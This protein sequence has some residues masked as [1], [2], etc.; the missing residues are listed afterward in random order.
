MGDFN[1][2]HPLPDPLCELSSQDISVSAP[3]FE[4]AANL[5][6]SLLNVPGIF[7]GFPFDSSSCPG[8]LVVS[9]ANPAAFP[10]FQSWEATLPSTGSDYVPITIQL[11]A[12]LL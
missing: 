4:R 3:Y 8:V 12:P 2:H 6:Y 11:S 7:T 9:F 1:L 10:F 5:G